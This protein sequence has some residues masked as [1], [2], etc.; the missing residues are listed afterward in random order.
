MK[1]YTKEQLIN[2]YE[3]YINSDIFAKY[4]SIRTKHHIAKAKRFVQYYTNSK[5]SEK[6]YNTK[7]SRVKRKRN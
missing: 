3:I 1:H 2:L 7:I 5:M 4:H 6:N